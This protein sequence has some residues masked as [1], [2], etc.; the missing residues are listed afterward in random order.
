MTSLERTVFLSYRRDDLGW[1]LAFFGDLNQHGYDVF[2]DFD[3]L[4]GGKFEP[5]ILENVRTRAHFLILLTPHALDRVDRPDDWLRREIVEAM[6]A[7]RNVVPILLKGFRFEKPSVAARL[8]GDLADLSSYQAV[9]V[10]DDQPVSAMEIVREKFLS[11]SVGPGALPDRAR[12]L[13]HEQ[14]AAAHRVVHAASRDAT[15]DEP[16][17]VKL[18][19]LGDTLRGQ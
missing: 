12:Q 7:E 14:Q 9:S 10:S 5:E 15:A 17:S 8:T 6:R 11:R 1:A 13:A 19:H 2:V 16:I 4:G 18:R 3:G